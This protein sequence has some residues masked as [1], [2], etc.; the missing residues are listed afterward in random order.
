MLADRSGWPESEDEQEEEG[1]LSA[2]LQLS[3]STD[4]DATLVDDSESGSWKSRT[5]S[6]T[7]E[8][9]EQFLPPLIVLLAWHAHTMRTERYARDTDEGNAYAALRDYP[10]PLREVVGFP[11]YRHDD[12][13]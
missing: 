4:S 1:P 9:E 11:F 7:E 6:G 10:F 5:K 2:S 8:E 12:N 13:A 3:E